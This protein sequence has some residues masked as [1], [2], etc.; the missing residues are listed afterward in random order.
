MVTGPPAAGKSA[1]VR[2]RAKDGD[3]TIDFDR[4]AATL[5]PNVVNHDPPKHIVTIAIAARKAAIR[6]ALPM[7]WTRDVY[8][9]HSMPSRRQ[10][11]EYGQYDAQII[12][13]D[14]GR[15]EC[16]QRA[17]ADNRPKRSFEII[18]EWYA[19]NTNQAYAKADW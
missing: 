5:T 15:E 12:T 11:A 1:W 6:T 17:S 7:S 18:N 16:L 2:T 8:V 9:I 13:L 3:I 14:P 10:L 19:R 4:M